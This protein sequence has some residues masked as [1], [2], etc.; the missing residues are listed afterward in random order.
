MKEHGKPW[1]YQTPPKGWVGIVCPV[2]KQL[3]RST[4]TFDS[5]RQTGHFDNVDVH[6][7]GEMYKVLDEAIKEGTLDDSHRTD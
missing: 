2:C 4:V 6:A 7:P 5:H 1:F 3:L